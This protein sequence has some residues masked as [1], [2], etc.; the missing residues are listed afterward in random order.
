MKITVIVPGIVALTYAAPAVP[1]KASSASDTANFEPRVNRQDDNWYVAHMHLITRPALTLIFT[2]R[3]IGCD[4][5]G[6]NKSPCSYYLGA[7]QG[8]VPIHARTADA[9]PSPYTSTYS[10][11]TS[12]SVYKSSVYVPP[13]Y[14]STSLEYSQTTTYGRRGD[15]H[16]PQH[17]TTPAEYNDYPPYWAPYPTVYPTYTPAPYSPLEHTSSYS[18]HT[19][20]STSKYHGKAQSTYT[21]PTPKPTSPPVCNYVDSE[22]IDCN[23]Y[24]DECNVSSPSCFPPSK[25]IH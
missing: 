9:E 20:T 11:S 3:H 1:T 16:P 18:L 4:V 10:S 19:S 23:E 5:A 7:A 25:V 17:K 22:C 21:S 2:P 12:H 8:A 15:Y 24:P 13:R 6:D 14:K